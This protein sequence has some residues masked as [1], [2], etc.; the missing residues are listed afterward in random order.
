MLSIDLVQANVRDGVIKPRYVKDN[1]AM[2]DLAAELIDAFHDHVGHSFGELSEILKVIEGDSTRF[3]VI[4]GFVKLL[5]DRC[6]LDTD[7]P[8]DPLE[9]RRKVFL[10]AAQHHPTARTRDLLH[11][12]TRHDLLQ[13]IATELGSTVDIIERSLYA[14]LK[15]AQ[16]LR[17]F[18]TL[19][20]EDLV[21]RYNV[22]LAQG[23]LMRA[24]E[25]VIDIHMTDHLS[26]ARYRA[27]F[28]YIKFFQLLHTIAPSPRAGY[29]IT[30]DGPSSVL[31]NAGRYGFQ[32]ACFLPALLAC[33]GW[34]MDAKIFWGSQ[35]TA[36]NFQ[37][38][39]DEGLH[40]HFEVSG[41]S[42]REEEKMF[43]DRFQALKT[44]WTMR[45]DDLLF[46]LGGQGLLIPDFRLTHPDG[47]EACLEI[48]GYWRADYLRRRLALLK[49]KGP[50]N[51]ILALS[52][53][54]RID[55]DALAELP[56]HVI[57]F[58]KVL[59]PQL[60]LEAAE[61]VATHP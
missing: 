8:I 6:D 42:L 4:R 31:Q 32:M 55:K 44:P 37:L 57:L 47:R 14:D 34:T 53:H 59:R 51:L 12:F 2:L 54:M 48:I 40:S 56:V 36:C 49:E 10:A 46:D 19:S 9:L 15:D 25:M 27:L 24:S 22:A 29:R 5:L 61:R 28:R 33:N 52:D 17:A 39:S 41:V 58:K 11:T 3:N 43:A 23:V 35:R 26:A 7:S 18:K 38:S 1:R 30:L 21:A 60:V 20:P 50:S 16:Q 45:R 13:Q